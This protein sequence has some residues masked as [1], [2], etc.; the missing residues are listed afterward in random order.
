MGKLN[1]QTDSSLVVYLNYSHGIGILPKMEIDWLELDRNTIL[2]LDIQKN[3]IEKVE[4]K[5]SI[6]NVRTN[7]AII[8]ND[9]LLTTPKEKRQK[10]SIINKGDIES[11]VR[12]DKKKA[13]ELYGK[14][15]KNGALL[16]KRKNT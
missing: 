7:M 8:F 10:L 4:F 16:I 5:D 1:A 12:I 11:I 6:I 13:I 2:S 9:T 15:G 3:Q 14:K